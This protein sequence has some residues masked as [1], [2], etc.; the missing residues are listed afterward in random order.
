MA[1]NNRKLLFILMLPVAL[2]TLS[3]VWQGHTDFNLWDEGFLWY[4]AQRVLAGEVPIR[5]FLAYDPT[6]YYWAAVVMGLLG[7]DGVVSLR[8]GAALFQALGLVLALNLIS[9]SKKLISRTDVLFLVACTIVLMLWMYVYYKVYDVVAALLLVAM[10]SWFF[11]KPSTT[12]YFWLGV[13]IGFVATIGRNHGVYALVGC[14]GAIAYTNIREK[15]FIAWVRPLPTLLAGGVVGFAPVWIAMLA[16]DGFA[17]AFLDS[18]TYLLQMKSTNLPLPVPWPWSAALLTMPIGLAVHGFFA[19]LCF[20]ALLAFPLVT[21]PWMVLCKFRNKP[22]DSALVAAALLSVPYAHYAFSRADV[23]HLSF[24]IFPL[25]IGCLVLVQE[26][27]PKLKWPL[28]GGVVAVSALLMLPLQPA[29]KCSIV[30]TCVDV[31]IAGDVILM[32]EKKSAEVHILQK[33]VT[34]YASDGSRFLVTP[35]WP[36]AYPLFSQKSP[37]FD[38]YTLLKRSD[39][40]QQKEIERLMKTKPSLVVMVE[41][42]LDGGDSH[43]LKNTNP[44]IYAYVVNHFLEV[45]VLGFPSVKAYRSHAYDAKH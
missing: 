36:G 1:L 21:I 12:R 19:G 10:L 16:V 2:V 45:P 23:P 13:C 27:Q 39:T 22:L 17:T 6:R 7:N 25:L 37:V 29:G 14:A 5:D 3:F 31:N 32:P 20:V 11:E 43:F 30:Y 41:D 42:P 15:N 40:F 24:S 33:L 44:L 4:G 28:L 18:I 34:Q 38:I 26:L 9:R 35:S 8:V